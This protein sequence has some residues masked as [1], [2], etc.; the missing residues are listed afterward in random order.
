MTGTISDGFLR[1]LET[2]REQIRAT[3]EAMLLSARAA[4]RETLNDGEAARH[5]QAMADLR[6]LN[7]HI[8]KRGPSK[9]PAAHLRFR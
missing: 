6:G 1:E 4:G 7:E 5:A 2:R 9:L 8:T 3:A